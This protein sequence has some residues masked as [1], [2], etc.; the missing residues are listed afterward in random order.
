MN[1]M[2]WTVCDKRNFGQR[3]S[4]WLGNT[5]T[6]KRSPCM[7]CTA[8]CWL[9]WKCKERCT[10]R[11][12]WSLCC[13]YRHL[14]KIDGLST[15]W[16]DEIQQRT[17]VSSET[18]LKHMADNDSEPKKPTRVPLPA[19][20]WPRARSCHETRPFM[21]QDETCWLQ[22]KAACNAPHNCQARASKAVKTL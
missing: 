11:L 10:G 1:T 18:P 21:M 15:T 9:S 22:Q 2:P 6:K 13:P 7:V 19:S 17:Q 16:R 8:H 14:Q 4:L 5:T 12:D 3:R 20:G